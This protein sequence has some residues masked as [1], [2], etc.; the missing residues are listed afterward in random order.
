MNNAGG[1]CYEPNTLRNHASYALDLYYRIHG[2]CSPEI[3]TPV[4]TDPCIYL[5]PS[6]SLKILRHKKKRSCEKETR[7]VFFS[8]NYNTRMLSKMNYKLRKKFTYLLFY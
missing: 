6:S 8:L 5:L 3:G 4:V 1:I 7:W 2:V